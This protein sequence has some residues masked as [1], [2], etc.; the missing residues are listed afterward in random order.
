MHHQWHRTLTCSSACELNEAP[1]QH[2]LAQQVTPLKVFTYD[3]HGNL[4]NRTDDSFQVKIRGGSL[5]RVGKKNVFQRHEF[6]AVNHKSE[7][8]YFVISAEFPTSGHYSIEVYHS[9]QGEDKWEHI[10]G[11]PFQAEALEPP[12]EEVVISLEERKVLDAKEATMN[13]D[14]ILEERMRSLNREKR[15][16]F[17]EKGKNE[18]RRVKPAVKKDRGP[19]KLFNLGFWGQAVEEDDSMEGPTTGKAWRRSAL[20]SRLAAKLAPAE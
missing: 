3:V 18:P 10:K 13:A 9:R 17:L 11:S 14:S 1:L 2:C 8:G 5:K 7:E 12:K 4:T 16:K 15:I 19:E 20:A 6:S